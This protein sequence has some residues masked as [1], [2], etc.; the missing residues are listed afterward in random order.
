MDVLTR[1]LAESYNAE[2]SGVRIVSGI[3]S[4]DSVYNAINSKTIDI[5]ALAGT[6]SYTDITKNPNIQTTQ[7]GSSAVV[8]ITNKINPGVIAIANP[9]AYADLKAFFTNNAF[10]GSNLNASAK[11]VTRSDASGT[12]DSFYNSFL[13]MSTLQSIPNGAPPQSSDT[14]LISYVAATPYTIGFADYGDVETAISTNSEQISII[15][16]QDSASGWTYPA[17]PNYDDMKKVAKNNY[18]STQR[19]AD[20]SLVWTGNQSV[21][22]PEYNLSLIYPL[23]YVTKDKPNTLQQGIL[24]YATSP[25]ARPAFMRANVFSVADF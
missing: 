11:A 4:P 25:A 19:H 7:I 21:N 15:S 23:Y 18:L 3:I 16:L 5:G 17:N 13:G 20:G 24:D 14:A 8:V 10:G 22:V 2:N 9:V 6:I 12:A 1:S